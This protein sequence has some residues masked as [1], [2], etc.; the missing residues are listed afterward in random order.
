MDNVIKVLVEKFEL[1]LNSEEIPV[2][3]LITDQE[4]NICEIS[5]NERQ[6]S[7]KICGHAEINVINKIFEKRKSKN[8]K[9]YKLFSTMEPCKMC[10]GA[11]EQ[12]GLGEVIYLVKNNKFGGSSIAD[13]RIRFTEVDNES[14]K[15]V[16]EKLVEYFR[17]LR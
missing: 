17:K 13:P 16:R 3:A 5:S 10:V 8:L 14:S 9:G 7:F 6:S 15:V 12:T 4:N 11:I 2:V 1:L